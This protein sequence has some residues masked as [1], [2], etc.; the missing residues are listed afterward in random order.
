MKRSARRLVVPYLAAVVAG[1]TY[2]NWW[3]AST[4]VDTSPITPAASEA[5]E[6]VVN[7]DAA[8]GN[9]VPPLTELTETLRRPLFRSDRRPPAAKPADLNTPTAVEPTLETAADQLRLVGMMRS[10]SS[11]R[12]ALI[13]VT[14]LP[15]A[16]W[17][18]VGGDVGGWTVGKIETDR[19]FIERNGDKAELKLFAP[20]PPQDVQTPAP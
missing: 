12:R 6:T 11:A 19:V 5:N 3:Q 17:V 10:G 16:A 18:E 1:L 8:T 15:T 14:G 2:L 13:R 20:K 9:G 7:A 4:P